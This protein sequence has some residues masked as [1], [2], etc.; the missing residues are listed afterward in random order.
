MN[1][2]YWYLLLLVVV[3]TINASYISAAE[4]LTLSKSGN[5]D[6]VIALAGNATQTEK[7]AADELSNYLNKI[8]GADFKVV[9]SVNIPDQPVLAV[10]TGAARTVIPSLDLNKSELGDDG[11]VVQACKRN[12]ILTGATNSRRGTIYAVYQFL[13][14]NAGVRWF[15]PS[16]EY[17]PNKPTLKVDVN[18]IRYVPA[19]PYRDILY[20]DM[21]GGAGT[22]TTPQDSR[23][24]F[25]VRMKV[26]GHFSGIDRKSV[27]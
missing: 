7:R 11:I 5:T 19:L 3:L 4:K 22:G 9:S 26:N 25:T 24:P 17:V 8:T 27:V 18:N 1:R 6:Y 15:T 23:I 21:I 10:G 14:D 12:L 2:V 16:E 13:E 20:Q